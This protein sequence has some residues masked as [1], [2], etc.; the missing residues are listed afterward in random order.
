MSIIVNES[1]GFQPAG[2]GAVTNSTPRLSKYLPAAHVAHSSPIFPPSLSPNWRNHRSACGHCSALGGG[3]SAA[4][5]VR[6]PAQMMSG[7]LASSTFPDLSPV[8]GCS[9][10]PRASST[11]L[12][13]PGL[14]RNTARIDNTPA[15]ADPGHVDNPA[16]TSA[17]ISPQSPG[18]VESIARQDTA[19]P[20]TVG[21]HKQRFR[22]FWIFPPPL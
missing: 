1:P 21:I 18:M 17:D 11:V 6:L 5:D 3:H 13:V 10:N 7:R 2:I 15:A 20:S 16:T 9:G 8:M 12:P 22:L 4:A 14:E 19:T